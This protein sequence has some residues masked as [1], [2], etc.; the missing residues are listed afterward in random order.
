MSET[1]HKVFKVHGQRHQQPFDDNVVPE[2]SYVRSP[3]SGSRSVPPF[4]DESVPV[5]DYYVEPE[6]CKRIRY[7]SCC[8]ENCL[9]HLSQPC[10]LQGGAAADGM[11]D[12]RLP[13]R[14]TYMKSIVV[15]PTSRKNRLCQFSTIIRKRGSFNRSQPMIPMIFSPKTEISM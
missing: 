7:F 12:S 3:L 14:N 4:G 11:R 2:P 13:D 10:R 5:G 1:C 6:T 8:R 15:K 9:P